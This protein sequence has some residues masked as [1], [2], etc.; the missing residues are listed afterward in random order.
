MEE[1]KCSA[2]GRNICTILATPPGTNAIATDS[3]HLCVHLWFTDSFIRCIQ[4]GNMVL[5]DLLPTIITDVTKNRRHVVTG[6]KGTLQIP[7][8]GLNT[9]TTCSTWSFGTSSVS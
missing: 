8:Y 6:A 9:V 2:E 1:L 3:V 4:Q 5:R 7:C